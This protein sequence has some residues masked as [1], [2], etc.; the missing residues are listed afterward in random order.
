MGHMQY[1]TSAHTYYPPT[2]YICGNV[3]K[4]T[5]VQYTICLATASCKVSS[6]SLSLI[7]RTFAES[8][9]WSVDR[10]VDPPRNATSQVKC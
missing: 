3:E 5:N 1:C 2:R 9:T 6:P 8:S 7:A 4:K 10:H